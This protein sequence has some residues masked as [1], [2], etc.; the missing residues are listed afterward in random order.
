MERSTRFLEYSSEIAKRGREKKQACFERDLISIIG[1][2]RMPC[3][4]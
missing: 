4:A 2:Y 3:G 1:D